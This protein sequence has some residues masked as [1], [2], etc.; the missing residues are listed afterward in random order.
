[1]RRLVLAA[2]LGAATLAAG[3]VPSQAGPVAFDKAGLASPAPVV[4]VQLQ[5]DYSRCID[6][7]NGAYT[8][9]GCDYRGCYPI[10]GIVGYTNPAT[11]GYG[12]GYP[13][14]HHRDWRWGD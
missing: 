4:Q 2:A 10:S 5:C 9:S 12:S 14:R 1:M 11:S 3:V 13:R 8:Q 7:R 6:P